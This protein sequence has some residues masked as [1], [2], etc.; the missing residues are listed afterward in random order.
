MASFQP[1]VPP[2]DTKN[3]FSSSQIDA[4][5]GFLFGIFYLFVFLWQLLMCGTGNISVTDFR[6][7]HSITDTGILSKKVD[8]S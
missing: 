8:K 4:L 2:K 6:Q 3:L 7:H 5:S 1:A